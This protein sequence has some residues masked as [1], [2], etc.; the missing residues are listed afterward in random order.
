MKDEIIHH[1]RYKH[2]K[3][4][5]R[6]PR[7]VTILV[8]LLAILA[9]AGAAFAQ[10]T[11]SRDL[12][13]VSNSQKTQIVTVA[14]GA[15][16]KQISAQLSQDKLIRSPWAFQLYTHAHNLSNSL[17]AGTYSLSP[18]QSTPDIVAVL[19]KG[20]VETNLVTILPGK[21]I[22]QIR[23]DLINDGFSPA[24]VDR[25]L[26]PSLY[27]GLPALA[28]KPASLNTLE[29]LLWPDSFQKSASTDPSVII[30]ESLEEMAEHLTPAVQQA[31]AADG[32]S[33][34]QGLTLSSI[35]EQE[36]SNP[37]DQTQV[38][39]VFLTRLKTNMPLGS[40]VTA[41][42]ASIEA[43]QSPNLSYNSP[44][45][46]LINTGLPPTPIATISANAL[47]AVEHPASTNWLYFVAGD[48]GTTYFSTTLAQHQQQTAQYCHKLCSQ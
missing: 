10:F 11:Y 15:S 30:R 39:Q 40:D 9:I 1:M 16:V 42:Y 38:A 14:D 12:R 31:F 23:A 41:Y 27:A 19:T 28:F 45:N 25:A 24:S 2:N 29:G 21:R 33:P 34:Y 6:I 5:S 32:L 4:R 44:Y 36:V 47:A 43:G 8:V 13:P 18:S 20:K 48:N 7:R 37:S 17:Q 35:V 26:S 3:K 22:D 46:T